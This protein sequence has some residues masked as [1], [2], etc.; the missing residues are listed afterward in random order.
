MTLR[1]CV[2][3][4]LIAVALACATKDE[5]TDAAALSQD[6]EYLVDA[7]VLV[8]RAGA[9]FPHQRVIADSLLD[10]LATSVDTLRVARTIAALNANPERWTVIF[11]AIESRLTR[12]AGQA[13]ES[14][15]G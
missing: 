9:F 2:A 4:L 3:S 6:E 7:Y 12:Y 8:R 13:S 10:H 11:S 1:R 5:P 14:T 15:R